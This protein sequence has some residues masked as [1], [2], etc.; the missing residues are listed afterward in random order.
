MKNA[1]FWDWHHVDPVWLDVLEERQV[2]QDLQ[3]ATSQKTA[4]FKKKYILNNIH[5]FQ[6]K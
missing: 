4:F 2:T 3:S 1:I 5:Y 6:V